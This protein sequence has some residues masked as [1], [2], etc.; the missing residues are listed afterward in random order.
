MLDY[1]YDYDGRDAV[2]LR[3]RVSWSYSLSVLDPFGLRPATTITTTT[4]MVH[5]P[6]GRSE[7]I[8]ARQE[9][10]SVHVLL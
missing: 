2:I 1:E 5:R 8:A 4:A 3:H 7:S 10:V 6:R 9:Q